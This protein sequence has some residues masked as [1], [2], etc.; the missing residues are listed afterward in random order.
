MG[1]VI[2]HL[3]SDGSERP[4]AFALRTMSAT[5]RKYAQ[6]EKKA[7][8][9][10]YGV[11][12]FHRYLYSRK[13]TLLTDHQPLTAILNPKMG[14]PSLTAARLQRWALLLSAYNYDITC[15]Y[16]STK[17]HCNAA[18]YHDFRYLQMDRHQRMTRVP[19]LTLVKHRLSRSIPRTL[20]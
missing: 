11:K 5:E 7:L 14:I 10:V 9:F 15:S 18:G 6:L 1:A 3:M 13:C 19:Y 4:I 8:S 20:N 17:E 12:K 16:K 2:S